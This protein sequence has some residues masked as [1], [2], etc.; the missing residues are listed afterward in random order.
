MFKVAPSVPDVHLEDVDRAGGVMAILGELDRANL[1]NR[2]PPTVHS[3]SL[4]E[5]LNRWDIRRTHSERVETFYK[6][7]PGNVPTQVGFSRAPIYPISA[8]APILG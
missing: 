8:V 7:A 1:I 5:V 3:K 4:E 2:E 6:A